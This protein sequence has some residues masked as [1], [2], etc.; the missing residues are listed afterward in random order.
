MT[1]IENIERTVATASSG[2]NEPNIYSALTLAYLGDCVY[3]LYV[4]SHLTADGNHKVN[5]LHKMATKFV[6]ASAQAEFYHRIEGILTEEEIS[7]F[8]RGRNAKSHPPKNADVIDYK[9][10]TGVETLIGYLYIKG[11]TKRIS[12]LITHLF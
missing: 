6:C 11:D 2:G 9:I 8:K 3:E 12:E 1:N 4:R 5:D 7:A 10:A